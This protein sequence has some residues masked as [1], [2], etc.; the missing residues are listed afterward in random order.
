METNSNQEPGANRAK[1]MLV[2]LGVASIAMFF[3]AFTSAYI[4]LQADHFW[5]QDKLPQMFTYSTLL[6][7]VSSITIFLAK[8]SIVAGNVSGLKLWLAL[9]F[10]LGLGF[11]GTQYLG[12]SE[13]RSE[14]K[15]FLGNLGNLQ[16]EYGQDYII[17]MK[18]EP[19][20]YDQGNF[21][22]PGDISYSEPIN[23]RINE[24]FNVSASFLYILSGLHIVHLLGG[25]IWLII[26]LMKAFSGKITQQNVLPLEL[27]SIYWHFLDILW[28]YLF[29]FLL[30]IR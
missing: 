3:A 13:L 28:V 25:I 24:T 8:Q 10:I 11:T 6:L 21:Y 15:F 20:L 9:T 19:V 12:W 29:L 27:G 7:V 16:G 18:G 2:W 30:L 14:G 4:V 5:V 26:L 1:R 17:L 22:K 23:E